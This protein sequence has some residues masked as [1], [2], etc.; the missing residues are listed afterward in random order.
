MDIEYY[1][2]KTSY[3]HY[4]AS[5]LHRIDG[6]DKVRVGGKK[7][8]VTLS[9]YQEDDPNLDALGYNELCNINGDHQQGE[10][11]VH[12]L[13]AAWA[14]V[15]AYY[16]KI[17]K[18]WTGLL[19]KDVS[20]IE[21][22]GNN[23]QELAAFYLVK[24]GKTW[25]ERKFNAKPDTRM[26]DRYHAGKKSLTDFVKTKPSFNEFDEMFLGRCKHGMKM[27][28][29][30]AYSRA[31]SIREFVEILHEERDCIVFKN[32]LTNMVVEHVPFIFGSAW[33]IEEMKPVD[34]FTYERIETD[35]GD[36]LK[37]GDA[38]LENALTFPQR[39]F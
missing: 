21:C 5:V 12:L 2:I 16:Y 32:W 28:L 6:I 30:E 18:G 34:G 13:R 31:S 19:F 26:Q 20:I 33:V 8:C 10:G 29:Q 9:I 14:F 23:K 25:Y 24:H 36:I 22:L 4:Y 37:G 1:K 15:I 39:M 3:A 17:A 7:M 38:A 27:I 35:P 11:S